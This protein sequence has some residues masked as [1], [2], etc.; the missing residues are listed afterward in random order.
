MRVWRMRAAWL[1]LIP[2]LAVLFPIR[3]LPLDWNVQRIG[4]D[5]TIGL[6]IVGPSV[7]VSNNRA[8]VGGIDAWRSI[9]RLIRSAH[10][11][12]D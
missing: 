12:R 11:R 7:V 9:A 3:V 8:Y 1:G 4:G 2:A 6:G 10:P 5:S